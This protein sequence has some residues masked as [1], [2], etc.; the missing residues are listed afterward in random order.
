MRIPII[1]V[2][3]GECE[4]IVGTNSHDVLYVDKESG[5]I[6]FLNI[7][8]CEGT[9]KHDGEQT[10]QFV[11]ESGYFEDIQIQFVTV[12]ALIELALQNM[13]N[14]TEQ[15]L[16]LHQMAREYLKA[17]DKCR[18]RMEEEYISDTSGALLF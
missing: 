1:K 15:K 8:C 6:Q 2:R 17:K 10:M 9:K 14:G 4:H 5:G 12:E 16:K 13:E 11:G 7:Q 3:D 18:E